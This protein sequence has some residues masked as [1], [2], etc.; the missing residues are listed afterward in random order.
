VFP[1]QKFISI[2]SHNVILCLYIWPCNNIL[3]AFPQS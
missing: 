2:V 1:P 3:L